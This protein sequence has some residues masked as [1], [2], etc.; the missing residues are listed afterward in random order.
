MD[1]FKKWVMKFKALLIKN[2]DR[3]IKYF[4]IFLSVAISV[5]IFVFRNSLTQLSTYGYFGIFLINL[6]G[7]ATIVIPAPSLV[8]TFVGGS[9]YNPLFVGIVSGIGASIGETTGYLAGYGGSVAITDHKHFKKIEKWM[10][11]NGFITLFVLS[12][13]PN[14]I[15][16]LS[17]IFAGATG[18][19][20]KK[21]FTA[22]L[23]GKTLRFIG[24]SF[25]GSSFL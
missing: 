21:Y 20:F 25:L 11:K 19:S 6:L 2:K 18:Y 24:I 4:F 23:I 17:G 22:V 15:F 16:D 3:I 9:I 8:A 12:V 1:K 5:L 13:I 10:N 7:S 14:P